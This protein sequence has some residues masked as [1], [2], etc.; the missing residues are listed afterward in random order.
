MTAYPTA[1]GVD[2]GTGGVRAGVLDARENVVATASAAYCDHGG[3]PADPGTWAAAFQ[4]A[5][6]D[7]GMDADLA[8]VGAVSVDGTS[9]RCW[10][11]T[12]TGCRSVRP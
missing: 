3:D 4:A 11:W 5:V 12:R 1:L 9:A 10:L 7:L 6:S 8:S 2:V